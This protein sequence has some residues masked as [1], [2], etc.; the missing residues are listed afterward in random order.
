MPLLKTAQD[1]LARLM[2]IEEA[3][4][5]VAEAKALESLLSELNLKALPLKALAATAIVLRKEGV[6]LSSTAEIAGAIDAIKKVSA[7]F[8]E[9]P[10]STTLKQGPRWTGL[11]K[12]LTGLATQVTDMQTKNWLNFFE[13]NF[14]GGV[15]P[16][17]KRARLTPT[18]ENEK[19]IKLY[20]VLFRDLIKYRT[21]I[22][23]NSNEFKVL[24]GLSDQLAGLKFQEDV[25]ADVRK[26][27][28]ATGTGASL[29]LL[30]KEVLD[31]LRSNNLLGSYIVRAKIN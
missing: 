27:F 9:I 19:M 29:E 14:F 2:K 26:F 5:G 3:R 10:K 7:C 23:K 30:T 15:P 4:E 24:K 8:S 17:K 11:I 18:P 25:P 31:W 21:Q 12:K 22:P 1:G 28:E 16:D 20:T 13:S 6:G